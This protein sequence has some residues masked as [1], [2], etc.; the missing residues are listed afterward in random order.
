MD[1]FATGIEL[2]PDVLTDCGHADLANKL[3]KYLKI[4]CVN[5]AEKFVKEGV[6]FLHNF[7]KI[8]WLALHAKDFLDTVK[9]FEKNCS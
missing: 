7:D 3:K 9:D 6:V 5:S 1:E 2:I 4:Q 8:E